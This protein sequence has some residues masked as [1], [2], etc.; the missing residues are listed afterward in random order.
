MME[1]KREGE[2]GKR[3]TDTDRQRPQESSV[4]C[5][6]PPHIQDRLTFSLSLSQT[7]SPQ[8]MGRESQHE[9]IKLVSCA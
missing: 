4:G 1:G 9:L 5:R 3:Q 2:D 7:Y 8:D 6:Q